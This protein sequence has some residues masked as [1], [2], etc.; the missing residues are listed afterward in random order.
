LRNELVSAGWI[1]PPINESNG[2][3]RFFTGQ[4]MECS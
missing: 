4:T 3:M 1:L 2:S